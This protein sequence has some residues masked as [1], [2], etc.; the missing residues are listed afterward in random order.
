LITESIKIQG[1]DAYYLANNNDAAR[2]LLYG[3][4]PVKKFK[5][6]FPVEMYLST[7]MGHE[8]EQEFFSKFGLEVRNQVDVIMSHRSFHQRL[9]QNILTRP[10][11]GDLIYVP[12]LNGSG[13]LYEIKFVDQNKDG[14]QLGRRDPYY[15]NMKMEKFKYSQEVIT[16]GVTDIDQAVTDSAYTIHLNTGAGTGTYKIKEL[17]FQSNDNTYANAFTIGTVQS[18]IPSSNTLSVT[19][20][21]GEFIDGSTIIGVN[22]NARY[23][24]VSFDPLESPAIKESYDNQVIQTAATTYVNVS[25][26][27]PIGGI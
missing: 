24:L 22:S 27:N 1:F 7:V 11:E 2:D 18:W 5:T 15:Y 8:G 13:E 19:N 6:A 12:F 23:A 21:A 25:E 4:D 10:R 3:E 9:P 16:T 17:V 14:F 26:I 20:I